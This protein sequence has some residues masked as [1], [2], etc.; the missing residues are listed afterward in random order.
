MPSFSIIVVS[1]LHAGER[2]PYSDLRVGAEPASI[3]SIH[4][5]TDALVAA[6]LEVVGET[7]PNEGC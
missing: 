3:D 2:N 4:R 1:D 5:S 7:P 6:I